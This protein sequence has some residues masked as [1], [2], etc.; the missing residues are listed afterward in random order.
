[1][2]G[3]S[4]PPSAEIFGA[5][6]RGVQAHN[7]GNVAEAE[8]LYRSVLRSD[9]H[10]FPALNMLGI[11]QSQRGNFAEAITLLERAL[12]VNPQS[13][14]A[15]ANLAHIYFQSGN[16]QQ[17]AAS[18]VRAIAIKPDFALAHSNYSGVLRSLGRLQEALSHCDQALAAQPNFVNALNNRANVLFDLQR[19][20]EALAGYENTISLAPGMPQAWLG[21]G[22]CLMELSRHA[23][24]QSAYDTA[25]RLNQGLA[26]AWIGRGNS[27][28][29]LR[30]H[31]EAEAAYEKALALDPRLTHALIGLGNA[32]GAMGRHDAAAD[33]YRRAVGVSPES[34]AAWLALAT[35]MR[36][37]RRH[38][39][40]L[41]ACEK[42]LAIDPAIKRAEGLRFL[43]KLNIWEWRDFDRDRSSLVG[44]NQATAM[45]APFAMICAT[46][47]SSDQ[48]KCA[49]LYVAQAHPPSTLGVERSASGAHERINVAYLSA[50]FGEHAV[51]LLTAGLF[52]H[53]DRSRFR[54]IGISLGRD[55]KSG[56]RD[57]IRSSF[58]TFID[59]AALGDAEVATSMRELGVDIAV[60]LMGY[61]EGSR[62]E[63]LARRAAP[64][65]VNYLGY[66][67]T[68]GAPFIDYMIADRFVIP[69]A[70]RDRYT[71]KIV[72]M[73]DTFQVN[74]SRRPPV[75]RTPSREEYGL[76]AEAFI[77]CAFNTAHKITPLMFDIWMRLLRCVEH[78]VLWLVSNDGR[79]EDRLRQEAVSR[80]IASERLLFAPRTN[81]WDYLVR[82]RCADLFLDTLPFN[83]GTTVSDA[84]WAGLPVVAASGE[85][86][87]SRMAGS[88]L[89][90]A[91]VPELVTE[92]LS[93]YESLALKLASDR[94][95]LADVKA[96]LSANRGT[97]PLFDTARFARHVESAFRTMHDRHRRGERPEHIDV[98][99]I[100]QDGVVPVAAGVPFR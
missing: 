14:D 23:E 31:G 95:M 60:D 51:S 71:E 27:A 15:Y 58:E 40:A 74:D 93:D 41:A 20:P 48:L 37:L 75:E 44:T 12:K 80:G 73:P 43:T 53:H 6:Q 7:R 35:A 42:A 22:N 69:V 49:E 83:G 10:N 2:Q 47:S 99:G 63:I 86:F 68:M 29:A 79:A 77:F 57:R 28:S 30:R 55:D 33:A 61:T 84:L 9:P 65:Q 25:L 46:S 39:D 36:G 16:L 90:A 17:A 92:S 91:G 88:L 62:P 96:R 54:T 64:I 13:A 19:H 97:C 26:E 38:D 76:P 66:P 94:A 67:A 34:A 81:Y 85:A 59:V 24:A 56:M 52:E 50:D 32:F 11:L 89:R 45:T 78:G 21:R 18:Y 98:A 82:Y 8:A 87:A 1:M 72:Y 100:G 5:L 4:R 70:Q 3:A